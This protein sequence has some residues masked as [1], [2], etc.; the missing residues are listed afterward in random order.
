MGALWLSILEED[1]ETRLEMEHMEFFRD[2]REG[3]GVEGG[4]AKQREEESSPPFLTS[5]IICSLMSGRICG[6]EVT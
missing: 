4:V 5:S 6:L 2:P 1:A 3:E